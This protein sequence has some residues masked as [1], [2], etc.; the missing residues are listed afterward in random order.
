VRD[1]ADGIAN[2]LTQGRL[3]ETYLMGHENLSYA[4]ALRLIA[5]EVGTQAPKVMLPG[6][7]LRSAGWVSSQVSR[8]T[9]KEPSF[10]YEMARIAADGHYFSPAKAVRELGLPQTGLRHAVREALT[11]FRA[12][13]YLPPNGGGMDQPQ[14]EDQAN[15]LIK[16]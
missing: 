4:E 10:T 15:H 8:L 2:A 11:W 12:H 9:G 5:E 13:Q 16:T 7:V 1:V 6:G 3:G 14:P